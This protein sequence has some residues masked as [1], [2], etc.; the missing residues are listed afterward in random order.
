MWEEF[1]IEAEDFGWTTFCREDLER[2][3][4]PDSCLHVQNEE[5]IRGKDRIDLGVDPAPDLV[6]EIDIA[7]PSLDKLSIYARLGVSE[8]WRY[9]SGKVVILRLKGADYVE[10]AE[11][12]VLPALTGAVLSGFVEKV[13]SMGPHGMAEVSP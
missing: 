3:F 1:G 6:I 8:V 7:S 5:R 4:E 12:M 10:V 9:E 13:R 11:S 2:G